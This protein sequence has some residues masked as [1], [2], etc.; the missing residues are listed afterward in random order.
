MH[1]HQA[2][3]RVL[4]SNTELEMSNKTIQYLSGRKFHYEFRGHSIRA[5]LVRFFLRFRLC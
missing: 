1:A 4:R 3:R 5:A 2:T